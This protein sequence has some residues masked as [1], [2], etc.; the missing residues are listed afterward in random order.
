MS[1]AKDK[2]KSKPA[3]DEYRA[4]YDAIFRRSY[5]VMLNKKEDAPPESLVLNHERVRSDT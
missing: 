2:P 4:N 1:A 5:D 3:T